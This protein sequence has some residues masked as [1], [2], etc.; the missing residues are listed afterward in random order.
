METTRIILITEVLTCCRM[1][2]IVVL[3]ITILVTS[4]PCSAVKCFVSNKVQIDANSTGRPE[5]CIKY[6]DKHD[7]QV[8]CQGSCS[9]IEE[10]DGGKL[11]LTKE[12]ALQLH[13][14]KQIHDNVNG[15]ER[16]ICYCN[17]DYC[18]TGSFA[19]PGSLFLFLVPLI[20]RNAFL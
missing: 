8:E 19:N 7:R 20:L 1:K 17:K 3:M 10:K 16:H 6:L 5:G 18:N 4:E 14:E 15:A 13:E 12:C 2:F 9:I 11:M